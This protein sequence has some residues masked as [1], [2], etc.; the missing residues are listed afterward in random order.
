ESSYIF[1]IVRALC[2]NNS[3]LPNLLSSLISPM[4]NKLDNCKTR[5][6]IHVLILDILKG[7]W[8]NNIHELILDILEGVWENKNVFEQES[9]DLIANYLARVDF[10]YTI[11]MF[12]P[13]E[14]L[15][16]YIQHHILL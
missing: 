7:V 14:I 4:A 10:T 12:I 9:T 2:S 8:E 3:E 1:G 15:N 6:H 13:S 11:N 16:S 5:I